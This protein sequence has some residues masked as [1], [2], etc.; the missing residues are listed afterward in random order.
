MQVLPDVVLRLHRDGLVIILELGVRAL[1]MKAPW[2]DRWIDNRG[3][4]AGGVDAA[5]GCGAISQA[6]R[7]DIYQ[8]IRGRDSRSRS[9]GEGINV[10]SLSRDVIGLSVLR[11]DVN[12][13]FGKRAVA[14]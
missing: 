1:G 7:G 13:G 10:K 12:L 6:R 4:G 11:H 2:H 5:R 3:A 14:H 9:A 8:A